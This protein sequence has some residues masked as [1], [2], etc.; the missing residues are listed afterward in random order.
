MISMLLWKYF[1]ITFCMDME[2]GCMPA[3]PLFYPNLINYIC[4]L[5]HT[6]AVWGSYTLDKYIINLSLLLFSDLII[7]VLFIRGTV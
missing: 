1:T 3:E 5:F 2:Y 7:D 6:H 4:F